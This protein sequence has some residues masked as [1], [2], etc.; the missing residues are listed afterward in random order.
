MGEIQAIGGVNEKIEGF[1]DTCAAA[2]LDG[3]AGRAHP[4]S[5]RGRADAA[6]RRG[7][8]GAREESFS[9]YPI[10]TIE[11]GIEILTGVPAGAP[12]E[13]GRFP[14]GTVYGK[15]E[16]RL[17]RMMKD[18]RAAIK[19]ERDELKLA[20]GGDVVSGEEAPPAPPEE[21]TAEDG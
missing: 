1:F 4:A 12:D 5:E 18:I 16:R 8:S 10:A 19:A 6:A 15:V 11:E 9:I 17:D 14:E 7:G 13:S 21:P 3:H 20:P 2:G